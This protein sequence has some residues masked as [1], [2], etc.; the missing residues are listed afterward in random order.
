MPLCRY[1]S[2]SEQ[3]TVTAAVTQSTRPSSRTVFLHVDRIQNRH[4]ENSPQEKLNSP[5]RLHLYLRHLAVW[6]LRQE[7]ESATLLCTGHPS[8]VFG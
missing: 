2:Y 3:N 8:A 1:Q 6:K 4:F 5:L 7:G